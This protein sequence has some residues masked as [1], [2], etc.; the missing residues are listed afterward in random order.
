MPASDSPYCDS[1]SRPTAYDTP[2]F[3]IRSP[4]KLASMNTRPRNT[5]PD[6]LRIDSIRPAFFTTP[7]DRSSG[8]PM[9][10]ATPAS[11]S[12]SANAVAAT[13]GSK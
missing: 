6:T 12:Q 2:A 8:S 13:F 9:I 3:A 11:R 1:G 4:S 5:R 10:T 7:A